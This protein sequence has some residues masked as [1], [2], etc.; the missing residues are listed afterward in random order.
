[1]IPL[2]VELACPASAPN[3]EVR[4]E[5]VSTGTIGTDWKRV[6]DSGREGPVALPLLVGVVHHPQGAVLID[7]GLG[8]TTRDGSFPSWP[9]SSFDFDLPAG[10]TVAERLPS[11]PLKVLMTH[12]HADHT[13][14]LLDWTG[15]EVWLSQ[16]EWWA[17]G[18]GG[19][20]FPRRRMES[21][22][23]WV[24]VDFGPGQATQVLGVPAIDVL[25]D[26]TIWYLSTPGHTPGSASVLV[27]AADG[28]WLFVGDTAWVESHLVDTRRPWLVA[29]L[30]DAHR[31]ELDESLVWARWLRASCPDLKIVPGHDPGWADGAAG[32]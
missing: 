17:Y 13:G 22:A 23:R 21:V 10:A 3:A 7:A 29:L 32:G 24:P 9:F 5:V 26:G 2:P 6:E 14:G 30:D 19:S 28:P 11:P 15:T 12:L 25:G 31:A 1:M 4:V 20:G 8:Q 16:Q 18:D 27:R